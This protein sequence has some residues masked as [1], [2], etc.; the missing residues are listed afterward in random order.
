MR[1]WKNKVSLFSGFKWNISGLS[2]LARS[3]FKNLIDEIKKFDAR[4]AF[5]NFNPIQI[6]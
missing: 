2:L 3:E 1:R 5:T 4:I 6:K